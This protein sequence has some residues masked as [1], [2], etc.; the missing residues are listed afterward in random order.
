MHTELI[1]RRLRHTLRSLGCLT[2]EVPL[3]E[4]TLY[5][6]A[7]HHRFGWAP[8]VPL[9]PDQDRWLAVVSPELI[10]AVTDHLDDVSLNRYLATIEIL[11]AIYLE[12][13]GRSI[14]PPRSSP[15]DLLLD[16]GLAANVH[17]LSQVELRALDLG[18]LGPK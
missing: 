1:A 15:E 2:I 12:Q 4:W 6:T 10:A 11:I 17:L 8:P 9:T 14:D 16:V 7:L 18:L 13:P 3:H 5:P